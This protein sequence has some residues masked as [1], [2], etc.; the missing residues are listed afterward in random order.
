MVPGPSVSGV[1]TVKKTK[2]RIALST[3]YLVNSNSSQKLDLIHR[4]SYFD[5]NL[6]VKFKFFI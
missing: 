5:L 4:P 6:I 3:C 1:T 2:F